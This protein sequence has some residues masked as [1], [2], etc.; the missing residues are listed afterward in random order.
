MAEIK[1]TE[2]TPT[3]SIVGSRPALVQ[4]AQIVFNLKTNKAM[5]AFIQIRKNADLA[6]IIDAKRRGIWDYGDHIVKTSTGYSHPN[7]DEVLELLHAATATWEDGSDKAPVEIEPL[8][9]E[10]SFTE[11]PPANRV[12]QI[13]EHMSNIDTRRSE[14]QQL[15]KR[16]LQRLHL[17]VTGE[18]TTRG[19]EATPIIERI[20]A[21]EFP[22]ETHDEVAAD[23]YEETDTRMDN[24]S[25][26][27]NPVPSTDP[28]V[29]D[30]GP[31]PGSWHGGV[32]TTGG[33]L[34]HLARAI[35]GLAGLVEVVLDR[36]KIL[37]QM[38]FL[39]TVGNLPEIPPQV[40]EDLAALNLVG[41]VPV[42]VMVDTHID[43]PDN[44]NGAPVWQETTEY[45]R[46]DLTNMDM[47]DLRAIG[48]SLEVKN[49]EGQAVK[50]FLVRDILANQPK[51]SPPAC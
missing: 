37:S 7:N 32:T 23:N 9:P 42:P 38:T 34:A 5:R 45:T 10:E 30:N 43:V 17:A 40:M 46:A 15:A 49:W 11:D 28:A 29:V 33:D 16:P 21:H 51:G 14:L 22:S 1:V 4:L 50:A 3:D 31:A 13:E 41:E 39:S 18:R 6:D 26:E 24:I 8:T 35:R 2:D 19:E 12:E 44:G 25:E 20:L 27:M 36:Q 47:E 48:K